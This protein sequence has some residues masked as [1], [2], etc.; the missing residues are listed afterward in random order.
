MDFT[1]RSRVMDC[2]V[3][4]RN[5]VQL[6]QLLNTKIRQNVIKTK[7]RKH[8]ELQLDNTTEYDIHTDNTTFDSI[9]DKQYLTSGVEGDVFKATLTSD[10]DFTKTFIIKYID[11]VKIRDTKNIQPNLFSMT[12]AEFHNI[13]HKNISLQDPIFVELIC[14]TLT[15]QLVLQKICPHFKL[16]YHW[17]FDDNKKAL[18]TYDEY[19]DIGDFDSWASKGWSNEYWF[20]AFF[21]ILIGLLALQ[22]YFHMFHCDF[23]TGNILVKT[24]Q[25]GGYWVYHI[26]NVK[27]RLPNLGFVILIND[28]GFSWIP[29]KLC[30]PWLYDEKLKYITPHGKNLYDIDTF[31][32]SIKNSNKYTVPQQFLSVLNNVISN[33]QLG[34]IMN[35]V[36]RKTQG[37]PY[38]ATIKQNKKLTL[39]T[40]LFDM[41]YMNENHPYVYSNEIES[42]FKIESYNLNIKINYKNLHPTFQNLTNT[43]PP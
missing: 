14:N 23:H 18:I 40:I 8:S 9:E 7:K 25:P 28:F 13:F 29:G 3:F 33:E 30:V 22:R 38:I 31:I 4:K 16:N 36:Y 43:I 15:S 6:N 41:F 39:Q 27:Y 20:N 21:Q 17:E 24:V 1:V 5:I 34:L 26:D 2:H 11:F 37:I 19:A 10:F 35:K 12:S 32:Q 42:S